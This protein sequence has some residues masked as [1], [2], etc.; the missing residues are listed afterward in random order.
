MPYYPVGSEETKLSAGWLIEA[1]GLKGFRHGE[2]GV[3]ERHALVLV[4]HGAATGA[5]LL[6]L[7]G[8]VQR[9][10]LAKFGVW[11]DPEPQF[12]PPRP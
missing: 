1:C 11:L 3:S 9:T 12:I 4:N 6:S 10:V 7:A 2:A 8:H 5:E